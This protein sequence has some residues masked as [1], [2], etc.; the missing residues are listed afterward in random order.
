MC[1]GENISYPLGFSPNIVWY[2]G[3]RNGRSPDCHGHKIELS[4]NDS[5][6][7]TPPN[8]PLR[9]SEWILFGLSALLHHA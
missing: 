3:E 6:T 2:L 8:T 9:Y 5:E 4:S 7:G 1:L